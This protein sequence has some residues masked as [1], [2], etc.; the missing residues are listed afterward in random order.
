MRRAASTTDYSSLRHKVFTKRV[1]EDISLLHPHQRD[2]VC[3]VGFNNYTRE[4]IVKAIEHIGRPCLEHEAIAMWL[5]I[6]DK[7]KIK[8][9]E[10]LKLLSVG[11]EFLHMAFRAACVDLINDNIVAHNEEGYIILKDWLPDPRRLRSLDDEWTS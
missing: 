11:D 4:Q 5:Q 10:C 9:A 6:S 3:D 2:K 7:E 8:E 1:L